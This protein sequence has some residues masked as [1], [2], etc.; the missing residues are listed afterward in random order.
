MAIIGEDIFPRE[1]LDPSLKTGLILCGMGG[2]DGPAAIRPFLRNLFKDPLIFPAPPLVAPL[3]GWAISTFRAPSV[4]TRYRRMSADCVSPQMETTRMQA[5]ALAR[6]MK[7]FGLEA[8]PGIAMRYWHPFPKQ[9]VAELV[10]RGARQFLVVPMYPQ[11]SSATSGSTLTAIWQ[12]I[13]ES[14]PEAAIHMV[15]GWGLL[16]GFLHT[17]AAPAARQLMDWAESGIPANECGLVYVAHSLPQATIAEGDPYLAHTQAT[18]AAVNRMI[19][20]SVADAGYAT[21]LQDLDGF[22]DPQPA[23]QSKVGP[24]KWLEPE[25]SARVRELA[26]GG[27]TRLMIQ[28]VSFTCEHIETLIELDVELQEEAMRMGIGEFHRGPALNMDEDWIK[29]MAAML[30]DQAFTAEVPYRA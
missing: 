4:R 15:T 6:H 13:R 27:C 24:I 28:P 11:Y 7:S 30:A 23:F 14:N 18:V 2:P 9:T 10:K 1:T 12:G 19:T 16:P 17:L 21:W 3:L 20:A 22:S 5:I 25:I 29:A 26:A 8:E